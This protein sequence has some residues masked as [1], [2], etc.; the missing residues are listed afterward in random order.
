MSVIDTE[1]LEHVRTELAI[2]AQPPTALAVAQVLRDGNRLV[3]DNSVL[4]IVERLRRD[5]GLGVLEPLLAIPGVTDVL[6]NGADRIYFDR[7][8]GL[9]RADVVFQSEKEVRRFAQRLA[10]QAGRRLDDASPFVDARLPGGIRMHAILSPV[11][12]PGTAISLRVMGRHSLSVDELRDRGSIDD[13][14][15]Q[16]L[17][18]L[19]STRRAF[20]ISGGTGAGKTTILAALLSEIPSHERIVIVE[21]SAEL[22]PQHPHVVSMESRSVNIEGAGMISMRDLVRQALRMR[23]D[24]LVIGEVRG[25][26]IV[27]LLAALNTGHEG[28][29]GTIHANSA[30]DVPARIEALGIAAGLN[31]EA[32]HA[33]LASAVDVIVHVDR[34]GDSIRHVREI[35]LT[36]VKNDRVQVLSAA[37]F[38][39]GKGT[40]IHPQAEDQMR[41]LGLW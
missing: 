27:E 13:V 22:R 9:E 31:R 11:A 29:C 3:G 4:T 41:D 10:T 18:S 28:G 32:V 24:R 36:Q 12:R 40:I 21:D 16:I 30:G 26:E 19:I 25:G 6:V 5:A 2:R 23:P 37:S 17:R 14:M 33:Q 1:L 39:P 35:A 7:G 8:S 34:Q 20:V 38:Q 15:A